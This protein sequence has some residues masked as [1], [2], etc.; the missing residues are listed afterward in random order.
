M[1]LEFEIRQCMSHTSTGL[2]QINLR[3]LEMQIETFLT[4][5][6]KNYAFFE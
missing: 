6:E 1:C 2:K 4:Q 5:H 3:G